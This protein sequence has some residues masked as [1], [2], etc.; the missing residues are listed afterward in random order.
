MED[1]GYIIGRWEGLVAIDCF[2]GTNSISGHT[3][4]VSW[5]FGRCHLYIEPSNL[6]GIFQVFYVCGHNICPAVKRDVYRRVVDSSVGNANQCG[7]IANTHSVFGHV[8]SNNDSKNCNRNDCSS[9]RYD[10]SLFRCALNKVNRSTVSISIIFRAR[11][12]NHV[13]QI[14]GS[15]QDH[16]VSKSYSYVNHQVKVFLSRVWLRNFR[17]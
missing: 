10:S 7:V 16:L 13:N 9:F 1:N 11:A 17:I 15:M 3:I 6:F 5:A 4:Q 2:H 14:V 12:N 8:A